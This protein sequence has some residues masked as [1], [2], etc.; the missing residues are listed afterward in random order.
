MPSTQEDIA[1]LLKRAAE[2]EQAAERDPA[3]RKLNLWL[4]AHLR[5]KAESL[6]RLANNQ[7]EPP[8]RT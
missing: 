3:E 6:K 4:A 1:A 5:A 2:Y 8:C 7:S